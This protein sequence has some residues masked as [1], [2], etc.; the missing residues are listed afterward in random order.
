MFNAWRLLAWIITAP[1][2][3]RLQSITAANVKMKTVKLVDIEIQTHK[4][5]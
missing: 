2:I 5:F 3:A 4:R 1:I